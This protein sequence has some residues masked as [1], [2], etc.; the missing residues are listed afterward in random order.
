MRI[1]I[2]IALTAILLLSL[3]SDIRAVSTSRPVHPATTRAT[4]QRTTTLSASRPTSRKSTANAAAESRDAI[5]AAVAALSREFRDYRADPKAHPLR[6]S[7]N[8]FDK[9]RRGE[10]IGGR[11]V[12]IARAKRRRRARVGLY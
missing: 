1:K 10:N 6:S 2:E 11:A 3:T 5:R 9:D 4:T 7:C 8:Y 12:G